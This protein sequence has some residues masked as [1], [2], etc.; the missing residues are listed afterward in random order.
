MAEPL[1]REELARYLTGETLPEE[2]LRIQRWLEANPQVR[3]EWEGL[4]HLPDD[5]LAR[6]DPEAALRKLSE[7]VEAP[8][9]A[10]R[11]VRLPVAD[12]APETPVRPLRPTR[13][14]P[15]MRVA[16]MVGLLILVGV[17]A[18]QFISPPADAPVYQEYVAER[19]ERKNV[20][21]EDG[22]TV[23]LNVASRLR[24]LEVFDAERR[25]VTLEGE[26]FFDVAHD[27]DRPFLIRSGDAIVQVLGTAFSIEAYPEE[28]QVTVVVTEGRVSLRAAT[29]PEV[30]ATVLTPGDLGQLAV[31]ATE[32]TRQRVDT[33]DYLGW[34]QGV[35]LFRGTPLS[36]VARQLARWHDVNFTFEDEQLAALRLDATFEDQPLS[37]ILDTIVAALDISYQIE[38]QQITFMKS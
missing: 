36:A 7:R 34:R 12:R 17:F 6:R 9:S 35:L 8:T 22:T 24:V 26:A 14:Y 30:G 4:D 18:R 33:N 28:D 20:T 15:W 37:E 13:Q 11:I 31:H 21:L 27:P 3:L 29:Q 2:T 10:G 25:E 38:G 1:S 32:V 23:E 5:F 16:A 19:G